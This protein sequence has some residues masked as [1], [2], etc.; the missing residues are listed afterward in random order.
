[1][2]NC[3]IGANRPPLMPCRIRNP[4]REFADHASPHIAEV[5]VN[6]EKHQ[7]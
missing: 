7:R 2:I 5:S 1:M 3:A 4:I 6:A